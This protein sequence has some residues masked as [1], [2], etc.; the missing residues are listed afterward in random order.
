MAIHAPVTSVA[1]DMTITSVRPVLACAAIVMT[2]IAPSA[3]RDLLA[4]RPSSGA[5]PWS[6]QAQCVVVA[7]GTDY[8]DEQTHTWRL[9]GE[10]PTPAPRGSA[11]VYYVWPATWS[12]QGSGRKTWPSR[13]AGGREQ[14]ERWTIANEMKTSI[15]ITEVGA[16]TGRLRIGA[17]GQRGAPVG[18]IRVT[19]ISGRTNVGSVQ[20]W[21][22]PAIEDN[23]TSTTISG[24]STKTYPEGFGVGWGQPP[25]A[26]TTA[27]CTWSFTRGGVEQSSANK[28]TGGAVRIDALAGPGAAPREMA[29]PIAGGRGLGSLPAVPP[30]EYVPGPVSV[31][32]GLS[33]HGSWYEAAPVALSLSLSASGSWY[34]PAPVA[35]SLSLSATG[36]W[37]EAAP[38]T[39]TFDLSATGTWIERG[40]GSLQPRQP[41]APER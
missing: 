6:G 27:T 14:S 7:K 23:A 38:V 2:V 29:P 18:S 37:Y 36:S 21:Q 1:G 20:P 22:F 24:T 33:A 9:T 28:P 15:R 3:P 13:E 19:E 10:V 39:V 11:Q 4:Q 32:L 8:G 40:G 17:E 5:G 34:E 16:G 41:V 12:V 30:A 31:T 26:I 35:L 25:K